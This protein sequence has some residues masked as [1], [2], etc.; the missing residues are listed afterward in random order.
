MG[1]ERNKKIFF[2]FFKKIFF[3]KFCDK[4][5]IPHIYHYYFHL[6]LSTH[7][8]YTRF[9]FSGEVGGSLILKIIVGL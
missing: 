4:G 9:I 8:Y 1:T 7:F 3:K 6:S 2:I 5:L